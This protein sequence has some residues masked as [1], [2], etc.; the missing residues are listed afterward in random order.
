MTK[1]MKKFNKKSAKQIM[2][3]ILLISLYN[4]TMSQVYSERIEEE[5]QGIWINQEDNNSKLV[6]SGNNFTELYKSEEIEKCT[7]MITNK[8]CNESYTQEKGDFINISCDENTCLKITGLN[9]N[10]L[11]VRETSTGKLQIFK[12][13]R[14]N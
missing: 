1:Q 8:S 7:F 2:F 4:C 13:Y 11:S 12:K 10:N 9:E 14:K 5:L 6:I 3:F